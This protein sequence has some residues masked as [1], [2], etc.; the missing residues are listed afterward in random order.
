MAE[1][2][3]AVTLAHLKRLPALMAAQR[4]ADWRPPVADELGELR[5]GIVGLG[6]LGRSTARLLSAFGADV[7]GL[8]RA[9]APVPEVGTTYGPHTWRQF[10]AGLD[11]L[12]ICAPLTEHTRGMIGHRELSLLREGAFLVN[13]GRGPVVDEHALTAALGTGRLS[14]AALDVFA[15]EP[16]PATSPLWSTPRVLITP[17]C[18]DTTAGTGRRGMR[19]LLDNVARHRAGSPLR[20]VVDI[21]RGY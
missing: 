17:H 5:V 18:A 4:T 15:T 13:V 20:N 16:L 10:Y 12:V 7:V 14:G 1:H 19:L 3:V 11:L 9:A 21:A 8:R 2:V 6:D